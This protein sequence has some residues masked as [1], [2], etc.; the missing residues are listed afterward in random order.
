MFFP[1]SD[2]SAAFAVTLAVEVPIVI[3][4]VRRQA[5][6]IAR[7]GV[8]IVAANLATHLA[9]WYVF[10]QLLLVGTTAYLLVSE[11]WAVGAEALVYWAALHAV[12]ARRAITVSLIANAASFVVGRL[13]GLL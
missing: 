11:T 6:D 4:L 1:V 12:S 5:P 8:I 3:I 2:W 9:V 13:I 7:L 10:T